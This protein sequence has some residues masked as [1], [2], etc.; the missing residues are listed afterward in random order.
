[1]LQ[2]RISVVTRLVTILN[3]RAGIEM[4][5]AVVAANGKSGKLIV[6][7]AVDR[8]FDVTA[9][10]RSEN[11][12]VA[13]NFVKKDIMDLTSADLNGF[14]AVVDA[15]GTFKPD[16][17]SQHSVTLKHL[18]DIL[19]KSETRLLIVGG[20]GSRRKSWILQIFRPNSNLSQV[21]KPK[22]S[23][24]S[25]IATMLNGHSSRQLEI[26]KQRAIALENIFLPAKN[27]L[28]IPKA[29]ASSV[30]Q[31]MQL[32]WLTKSKREIIFVREFQLSANNS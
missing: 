21:L 2:V 14:D 24:N 27:L 7:E 29:K 20:A 25:E 11:K 10:A 13:K 18:C 4:K 1:M 3:Q 16:T 32:Q 23:R 9:I 30:M 6:K 22:L 31:I 28:S 8:G 19:S 5:I 12:T 26:F 15:F 17:L